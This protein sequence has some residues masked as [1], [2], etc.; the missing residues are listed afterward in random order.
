MTWLSKGNLKK[1]TESLLT[2][3]QN[4]MKYIIL[5]PFFTVFNQSEKGSIANAKNI[6]TVS[7]VEG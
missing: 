5:I 7:S 1:E 6:L 2:A 4:N 3:A